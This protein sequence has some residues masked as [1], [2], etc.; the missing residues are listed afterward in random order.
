MNSEDAFFE[1]KRPWSRI[2]DKVI[3]DYLVPYLNKVSKLPYKIVMVD[4]F[5]G[6]G[7]FEDGSKGSPLI[8]CE[9]AEK[10]VPDQYLGVFVNENKA[11]HQKLE[12]ALEGYIE[13]GKALPILGSAE[14]LLKELTGT[15][16]DATILIYLDPFGLKGC[17]FELLEPYLERDKR[18][19]TEIIVNLSMPTLHRLSTVKAVKEGRIT[20]TSKKLNERLSK[21]LGGDYWQEIMWSDVVAAEKEEQVIRK[22]V[23]LLKQYLPYAGFCPV[24]EKQGRRVK[25]YII[26]CSRHADALLLMNDIMCKA[27]FK[28]MHEIE[29]KGT[30]FNG[31]MD[32]KETQQR[33]DI[34]EAILKRIRRKPGIRREDLWL[35]IIKE[36]FMKWVRAE[37]HEVI[38]AMVGKQ[39]RFSSSTSRLN[40]DPSALSHIM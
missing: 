27:Y 20:H 24:R 30:L 32:W 22:Y 36:H 25:Y 4:A 35:Q 1:G 11:S 33:G 8:I 13:K 23:A 7:I 37:Y 34:G 6:Q 14:D 17:E 16:R 18:F 28:T 29:S 10:H 39:I 15:I 26:F 19:S 38:S 3:G 2:K 40:D 12:T 31:V 5:A 21:I 9:A